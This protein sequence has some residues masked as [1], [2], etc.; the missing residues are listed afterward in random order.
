L[1][2]VSKTSL[3]AIGLDCGLTYPPFGTVPPKHVA[4]IEA[5]WTSAL[6]EFPELQP[7]VAVVAAT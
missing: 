5:F 6:T 7:N 3:H 4:E 2:A 1:V